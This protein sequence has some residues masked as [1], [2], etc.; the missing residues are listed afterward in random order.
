MRQCF[1]LRTSGRASERFLG[2]DYLVMWRGARASQHVKEERTG[3]D[4]RCRGSILD[5]ARGEEHSRRAVGET[6]ESE[7]RDETGVGRVESRCC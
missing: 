1:L 3:P 2:G 6:V 5:T 7:S 4:I